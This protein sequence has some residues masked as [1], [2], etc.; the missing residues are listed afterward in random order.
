M[1]FIVNLLHLFRSKSVDVLWISFCIWWTHWF[2]LDINTEISCSRL[3]RFCLHT[4]NHYPNCI[5]A[6]NGSDS[7]HCVTTNNT[8]HNV[9]N[10]SIHNITLLHE[11]NGT[12][13][14][15]T[16]TTTCSSNDTHV[17][18]GVAFFLQ[19]FFILLRLVV[20]TP[21][22]YTIQNHNHIIHFL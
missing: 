5:A 22:I 10:S 2:P 14:T 15:I 3:V 17:A 21:C 4:I 8:I 9:T 11:G 1:I 18:Q 13:T 20:T 12:N 7:V 6:E 19:N 16:T